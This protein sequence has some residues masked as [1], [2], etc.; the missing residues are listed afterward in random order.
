[1]ANYIAIELD[2]VFEIPV[3]VREA[4]FAILVYSWCP[5][6]LIEYGFMTTYTDCQLIVSDYHRKQFN[7]AIV[8]GLK[9]YANENR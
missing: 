2:K 6:I 1:M 9:K 3:Y 4:N 7:A 5:A 8:T